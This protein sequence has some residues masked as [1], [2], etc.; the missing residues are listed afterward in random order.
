MIIIINSASD[1]TEAE[2]CGIC[3]QLLCNNLLSSTHGRLEGGDDTLVAEGLIHKELEAS[4]T[5][6]VRPHTLVP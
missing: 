6:S 4:Y 2:E 5:R 3:A 1:S